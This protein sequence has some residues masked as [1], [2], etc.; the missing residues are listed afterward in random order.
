MIAPMAHSNPFS[1]NQSPTRQVAVSL[2]GE[3]QEILEALRTHLGLRT[4]SQVVMEALAALYDRNRR[5]MS[6][7]PASESAEA[8]AADTQ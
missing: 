3:Q 5:Q 8:D 6:Q 4:R 7:T 1:L 2:N